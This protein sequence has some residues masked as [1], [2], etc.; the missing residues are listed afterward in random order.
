MDAGDWKQRC[1][2]E[3]GHTLT[4]PGCHTQV[5]WLRRWA[6][7]ESD[8]G[9]RARQTCEHAAAVLW[10]CLGKMLLCLIRDHPD[11]DLVFTRLA[12]SKGNTVTSFNDN[13]KTT[14]HLTC[15]TRRCCIM[16][17]NYEKSE[18]VWRQRIEIFSKHV[19]KEALVWECISSLS[20]R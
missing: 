19:T 15:V 14:W 4:Q 10:C 2:T 3:W 16:L 12:S 1:K 6:S 7:V 13:I 11:K 20:L 5:T 17:V 18:S 8:T 9:S